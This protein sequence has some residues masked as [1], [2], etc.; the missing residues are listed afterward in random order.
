MEETVK[1]TT[2]ECLR[3]LAFLIVLA[4]LLGQTILH[5]GP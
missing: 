4:L 1:R 2:L 5:N 3:M